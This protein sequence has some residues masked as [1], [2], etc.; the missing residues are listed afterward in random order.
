MIPLGRQELPRLLCGDKWNELISICKQVW[1]NI[2]VTRIRNPKPS[3]L[4]KISLKKCWLCWDRRDE[5]ALTR[6]GR[7]GCCRWEKQNVPCGLKGGRCV[8]QAVF[9]HDGC[10]PM[11][12]HTALTM[13]SW[14]SP[15]MRWGLCVFLS[16]LSGPLTTAGWCHMTSKSKF[17]T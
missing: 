2:T 9:P 3:E 16:N 11:G 7:Q 1:R 8:C 17:S 6:G 15:I 5:L 10:M 12:C 4:R 13:W 14:H